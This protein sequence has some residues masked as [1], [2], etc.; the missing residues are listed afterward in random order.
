[1]KDPVETSAAPR[2]VPWLDAAQRLLAW[3]A[4][5]LRTGDE[6]ATID[7]LFAS[8]HVADLR[9]IVAV[10]AFAVFLVFGIGL[11]LSVEYEVAKLWPNI[12]ASRS[13]GWWLVHVGHLVF[14]VGGNFF[15]FFGPVV[16]VFGAIV[17]WAYQVG[18]ARLGVVDLFACEISTLCRVVTVVDAVRR[19]VDRFDQGP[20]GARAGAD[21]AR[22]PTRAFTSQENYFPV[23]D[24]NARDLQA[25]EARVVINITAFYTYMKAV[26]DSAR[27][28]PDAG[29][30]PAAADS[31]SDQG[32]AAAAWRQTNS[33]FIYMMFLGLES[34]RRAIGD[35]VEFEPEEAERTVVILISE[36][37]AYRFLCR[38]FTDK[39]DVHRQRIILRDTEYRAIVPAL[40]DSIKAGKESESAG[41]AAT[42]SPELR[43]D[44][45]WEPALRLLPE[46]C[47]RYLAAIASTNA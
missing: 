39:Q 40:C 31:P 38:Q 13:F 36:L 20:L 4:R 11:V 17:A 29:T 33:D 24:S 22:A 41:D 43:R 16:A 46:L 21:E 30:P 18:S 37:E 6:A 28:L 14:A 3:I 12:N 9:L 42:D 15:T 10:A 19:S 25:L 7:R 5:R 27:A 45:Q 26:R 23:F 2:R 34:A 1:M 35:L 8:Q 32:P 47:K 44:S